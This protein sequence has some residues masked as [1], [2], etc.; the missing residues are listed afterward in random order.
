M[1]SSGI[2][3]ANG[4]VVIK[5]HLHTSKEEQKRGLLARLDEPAKRWKFS[6]D[7]VKHSKLLDRHLD[8]YADMPGH[9]PV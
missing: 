3:P 2:S 9:R 4:T 6:I 8:A 5:F 7:D 1:P